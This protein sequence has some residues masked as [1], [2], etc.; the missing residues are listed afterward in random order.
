MQESLTLITDD[1]LRLEGRLQSGPHP[2]GLALVCHPYPPQGGSMSS[3]LVPTIQRSVA[4]RGWAALRFNFRGVGRSEGRFENGLGEQR[5]VR[6]GIDYLRDRFGDLP[7]A[8]CGWSF[9]SLVALAAC[10]GDPRVR[11]YVGV[12][13]PV[14]SRDPDFADLGINPI[15][16][17]PAAERLADWDV[18]AMT[19]LGSEDRFTTPEQLASW[20]TRIL[21]DRIQVRIVEGADHSFTG[22]HRELG[23]A[24][25][26]FI[27]G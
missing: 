4:G 25:A 3:L 27:A 16:A 6:A 1:A 7:L 19:I 26:S 18:R 15:Q 11:T 2:E 8:V 5:D 24:V 9:G 10:A 12:A 21:G 14:G 22:V 23:E 13:P 20:A 17:E